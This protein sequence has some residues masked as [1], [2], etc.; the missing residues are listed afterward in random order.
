[1][2]TLY[3]VEQILEDAIREENTQ[4]LKSLP[5]KDFD[6]DDITL[7]EQGQHPLRYL[8]ELYENEEIDEKFVTVVIKELTARGMR[9]N[10]SVFK[11]DPSPAADVIA[12]RVLPFDARLEVLKKNLAETIREG[13]SVKKFVGE[14]LR[15]VKDIYKN[16]DYQSYQREAPLVPFGSDTESLLSLVSHLRSSAVKE[17]PDP[18]LK[19]L[20]QN[21]KEVEQLYSMLEDANRDMEDLTLENSKKKNAAKNNFN[22][23]SANS[24]NGAGK[25]DKDKTGYDGKPVV[26]ETEKLTPQEVRAELDREFVGQGQAKLMMQAI[27]A[28][29][30]FDAVRHKNP[31]GVPKEALHTRISGPT[32]VGKTTFAQHYNKMLAAIGRSNGN[33]VHL[34]REK[35]VEGY[36]GQTEKAMKEFLQEAMGG[37]LF[38]DEVHNLTPEQGGGEKKDFGFRVVEA[39][40]AVMEEQ[41]ENITI[42]VA[43]YDE[44]IERFLDSD[45]GLRGRFDNALVLEAYG[46]EDL[47]RI[48]D[49]FVEKQDLIMPD[50]VREYALDEIMKYKESV[51]D[52][53]ANGRVIRNFV[54]KMPTEMALRMMPN[55][56]PKEVENLSHEERNT[57]TLADAKAYVDKLKAS[58]PQKEIRRPIGFHAEM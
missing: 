49:L 37:V 33:F 29:A 48:M 19:L 28:R 35:V 12:Q 1:M 20:S 54:E 34:T 26:K 47:G 31:D 55:A 51:G 50:E 23:G 44:D 36:I 46:R 10:E 8:E 9:G 2:N 18:D 4:K 32:G 41:R 24:G 5:K 53:F 7:G 14:I 17:S 22:S 43:G 25:Q 15:E 58:V 56:D 39:L 42:I 3:P 11:N 16:A 40:V 57:V 6:Y 13:G 38:I 21:L 27:A 52:Q 30:V 45:K